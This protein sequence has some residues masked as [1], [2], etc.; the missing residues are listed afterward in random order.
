MIRR[1]AESKSKDGMNGA[2]ALFQVLAEGGI[3][4]CF[5]NP[6]TTEMW[7]VYEMG[8]SD[9]I[10]PILCLHENVVTGAAD[11]YG[12]MTGKPALS[13]LHVACGLS[14]GLANLHNAAR[15]HTPMVNLVGGNATYHVPNNPELEYIGSRIIDLARASSHWARESKSADDLAVLASLAI[16]HS[17]T[18]AGQISTVVAPTN[19]L[20]EEATGVPL[21]TQPIPTPL[22]SPGTIDKVASLLKN[23]KRTAMILGSSTL[24][25]EGLEV[26]GRIGAATGAEILAETFITGRHARGEGRVP[27]TPVPY[28]PEQAQALLSQFTQVVLVGTAVPMS[29]MAYQGKP[30]E[31]LPPNTT[32][33]TLATVEQDLVTALN[34]LADAVNA[35]AE[36]PL[37]QKRHHFAVPTGDL[38]TAAI[39]QVISIASPEDFIF[40]DEGA[41]VSFEALALTRGAKR[42]DYLYGPTGAAIGAGMPL[43][44]G[45]AVACTHRK[46]VNLQADGSAMYTVMAL[47]SM[48]RQKADV[49]V[50]LLKNNSYGI[51]QIELARVREGEANAKMNSLLELTEP[52]LDWV[53]IAA[54]QGVSASRATSAEEFFEQYSAAMQTPGPHLI[55]ANLVQDFGPM[56]DLVR[57]V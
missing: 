55:E 6:G 44:L 3:D 57:Q 23:G 21:P 39:G 43:A 41:T 32:L 18:G 34:D 48:A 37:R 26:V 51:L 12:R 46:V 2:Q 36:P 31:K 38:T 25:E 13:L 28:L 30:V 19:H 1:G 11:G 20:W 22:A 49:T 40:V 8:K 5:A 16:R 10:Q 9:V 35:P 50:V 14:N 33:V 45:A 7:M 15:A 42:H 4:T 24:R 54:G 56:I 52:T 53:Q 17:Q 29:T 47:W 27:I